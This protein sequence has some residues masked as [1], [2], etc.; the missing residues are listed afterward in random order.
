M[1]SESKM[2]DPGGIELPRNWNRTGPS[3]CM[4]YCMSRRVQVG[5]SAGALFL[6]GTAVTRGQEGS[7][8]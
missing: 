6:A 2:V 7:I 3:Y 4:S 8:L 1:S 5:K